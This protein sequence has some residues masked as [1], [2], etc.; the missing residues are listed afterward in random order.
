MVVA[1]KTGF[2]AKEKFSQQRVYYYIAILILSFLLTGGDI[3]S[4]VLL[5]FPLFGLYEAGI[6]IMKIFRV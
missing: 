6:I 3:F 1:G 5:A 2:V 4:A